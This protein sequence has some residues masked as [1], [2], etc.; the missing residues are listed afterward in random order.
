MSKNLGSGIGKIPGLQSTAPPAKG[1]ISHIADLEIFQSCSL[2]VMY[3]SNK[4]PL[5]RTIKFIHITLFVFCIDW[6]E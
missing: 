6:H 1:N 5:S 2:R 3:I 4:S